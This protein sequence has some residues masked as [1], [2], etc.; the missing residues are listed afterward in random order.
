MEYAK[1]GFEVEYVN[2][3]ASQENMDRMLKVSGGAR[4]VPVIIEDGIL[5]VGSGGT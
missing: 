5:I 1:K 3:K 4:V 2:V